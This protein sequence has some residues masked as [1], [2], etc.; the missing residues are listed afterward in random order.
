MVDQAGELSD[1]H[2]ATRPLR[3]GTKG[4]VPLWRSGRCLKERANDRE[5]G[6]GARL[7]MER[8]IPSTSI[9]QCHSSTKI[10]PPPAS[11]PVAWMLAGTRATGEKDAEDGS[12]S[13]CPTQGFGRGTEHPLGL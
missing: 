1:E 9:T 4:G 13:C 3:P 5:L 8:S 6:S 10:D 2:P 12:G 7:A 11:I